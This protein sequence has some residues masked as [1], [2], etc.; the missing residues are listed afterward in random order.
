M[1]ERNGGQ[2]RVRH[3]VASGIRG[4]QAAS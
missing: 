2:V 3:E 4:E 1:L